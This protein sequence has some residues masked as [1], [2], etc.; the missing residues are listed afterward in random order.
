MMPVTVIS[1]LVAIICGCITIGTFLVNP[2]RS[3]K[4]EI[5]ELKED[6]KQLK[7]DRDADLKRSTNQVELNITILKTLSVICKHEVDGN[8]TEQ[9][10]KCY[11]EIDNLIIKKGGSL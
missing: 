3:N 9:L 10:E 11:E 7:A 2:W 6:V 1:S 8:H 5:K 4:E